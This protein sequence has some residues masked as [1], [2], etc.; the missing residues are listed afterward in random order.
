M[1]EVILD[2]VKHEYT[3]NLGN[4]YTPVST[5]ISN[6]FPEFNMEYWAHICSKKRG[7]NKDDLIS[8]WKTQ[9]KDAAE[10][11]HDIHKYIQAKLLNQNYNCK[12]K[13]YK[14]EIDNRILPH[15]SKLNLKLINTEKLVFNSNLKIAGTLDALFYQKEKNQYI[16][17]DWKTCKTIDLDNKYNEYGLKELHDLPNCNYIHYSLQLSLYKKMLGIKNVIPKIVH[18][19]PGKSKSY[20]VLNLDKYVDIIFK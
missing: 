16:L 4:T 20:D 18:I 19:K 2:E 11:G 6:Y 8:Q 7:I 5:L 3:D 10:K 14:D 13:D 12:Y 9:G 15:L 1:I 17:I